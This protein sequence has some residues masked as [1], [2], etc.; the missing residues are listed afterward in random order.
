[1]KLPKIKG[2][3][4][5]IIG[6]PA[7]GKTFMSALFNSNEHQ[8]FHTDDYIKYGYVESM[9]QCLNDVLKCE[10]NTIVEGV[11]G[12]RML[13]K[14]VELNNYY[15]DIIVELKITEQLMIATYKKERNPNKIKYLTG[16]NKLHDKILTDY[17]NMKNTKPAEWLIINNDYD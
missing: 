16:F 11:Q 6:C 2:K 3:N 17:K 15:P 1:M 13:R 14:G 9:Y 7:S 10:K 8:I 12:Y 5:L 4:I